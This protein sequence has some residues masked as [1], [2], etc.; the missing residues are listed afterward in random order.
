MGCIPNRVAR[1]GEAVS[2]CSLGESGWRSRENLDSGT[3]KQ[4]FL[5][6]RVGIGELNNSSTQPVI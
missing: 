1:R 6:T 3:E 4:I 2:R 5:L